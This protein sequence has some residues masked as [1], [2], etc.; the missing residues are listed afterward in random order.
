[1]TGSHLV[2][3][4]RAFN[5][6]TL[7]ID[8]HSIPAILEALEAAEKCHGQPTIIVCQTTKGKGVSFMEGK[9]EWHG[10]APTRAEGDQAIAEILR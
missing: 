6:N 3:K 10:K 8:G 7:E 2:D 5:W 9:W 1:M 4:W